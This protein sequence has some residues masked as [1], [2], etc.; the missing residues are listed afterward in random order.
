[1]AAINLLAGF[2]CRH[3]ASCCCC[4]DGTTLNA[5]FLREIADGIKNYTINFERIFPSD[6]LLLPLFPASLL[7]IQLL[8]GFQRNPRVV[9]I[10]LVRQEAMTGY[11]VAD[12]L[13]L[14]VD[15][16]E[17]FVNA[18]LCTNF[19]EFFPQGLDFRRQR[20]QPDSNIFRSA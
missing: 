19:V 10:V 14:V 5:H 20:V 2:L 3:P 7:L 16:D 15:R 6:V 18:A 11:P 8:Q 4:I 13:W 9:R 12:F 1:M 17:A